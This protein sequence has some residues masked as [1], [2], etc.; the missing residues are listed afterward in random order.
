LPHQNVDGKI[1]SFLMTVC[2][3]RCML[4]MITL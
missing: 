4:V 2:P 3:G 1:S